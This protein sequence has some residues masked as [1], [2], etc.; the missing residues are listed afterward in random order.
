MVSS[1]LC[2]IIEAKYDALRKK[3]TTTK[4]FKQAQIER[5]NM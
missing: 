5:E 3:S 1:Y 4:T 2:Y